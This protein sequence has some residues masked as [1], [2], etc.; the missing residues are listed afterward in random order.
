MDTDKPISKHGTM[1]VTDMVVKLM[2]FIL[3]LTFPRKASNFRWAN[4][5]KDLTSFLGHFSKGQF[6][7]IYGRITSK[8]KYH[9]QQQYENSIRRFDVSE[10]LSSQMKETG[11][12]A[13]YK[14]IHGQAVIPD[15]T[16]YEVDLT[17]ISD[18]STVST[19]ADYL[20][21]E[22]CARKGAE[23]AQTARNSYARGFSHVVDAMDYED[24]KKLRTEL[25]SSNHLGAAIEDT[26]GEHIILIA[27]SYKGNSVKITRRMRLLKEDGTP[28]EDDGVLA[29]T[30]IEMTSDFVDDFRWSQLIRS[31]RSIAVRKGIRKMRI[32]IDRLVM[33]GL[34]KKERSQVYEVAE[35]EDF[36]LFAY[37]VC[38]VVRLYDR[39]EPLYGTDF[40][41]KLETVLGVAGR[42]IV[43]DDYMLRKYDN[44]LYF[45]ASMYERL[46]NGISNIGGTG[47]YLRSVT[48]AL[49]TAVLTDGVTVSASNEDLRT[50]RAASGWKA[51]AL[52][53]IA[54]GAYS[55]RHTSMLRQEE[56]FVVSFREFMTIAFWESM[57]SRCSMLT[58]NSY[59]DMS[60]QRSMSWRKSANW[61]GI[62]EWIGMIPQCC[63]IRDRAKI[64]AFL[65]KNVGMSMWTSTTG[66][67]SSILTLKSPDVQH[68]RCLVVDLARY[69]TINQGHVI[70]VAEA[71][72][73]WAGKILSRYFRFE[74]DPDND[75]TATI[76]DGGVLYSYNQ[77]KIVFNFPIRLG[78]IF[79]GIVLLILGIVSFATAGSVSPVLHFTGILLLI[80]S[81]LAIVFGLLHLTWP[82]VDNCDVGEAV[83]DN[84]LLHSLYGSGIKSQYRN[85]TAKFEHI[86]WS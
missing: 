20:Y 23:A 4:T 85:L 36:G 52:R 60:Y 18:L 37:A 30:E 42:G 3:L 9:P 13:F 32:W 86:G 59:L 14:S 8:Y 7:K 72:G 47:I 10:A 68:K 35:W 44:T 64:Y 22:V 26:P 53:T 41:R 69:S 38:P 48:L 73:L 77:M 71:T 21:R 39:E 15:M 49:A 11:N 28:E 76:E 80:L 5:R 46:D 17:R 57:V 6:T 27:L 34:T 51:W 84:L 63:L 65:N 55:R 43:V 16:D 62:L 54:E 19:S 58:G 50:K 29:Q 31:C 81:V 74:P 78:P 70:A 12:T 45:G 56:A 66:H 82:W 40:W 2:N 61:D 79:S 24:W 33:M 25:R 75:Q 1:T 83:F 67:V